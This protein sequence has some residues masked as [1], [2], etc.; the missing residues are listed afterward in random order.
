MKLPEMQ[1]IQLNADGPLAAEMP[2][3]LAAAIR[4]ARDGGVTR[5]LDG[6]IVVSEIGPPSISSVYAD[7]PHTFC[8]IELERSAEAGE[9]PELRTESHTAVLHP[10]FQHQLT[11]LI[12][13]HSLENR[14]NTPDRILAA[15]LVRCLEVFDEATRARDA[16]VSNT[17]RVTEEMVE[18]AVRHELPTALCSVVVLRERMR[19]LLEVA[20]G[21]RE[22]KARWR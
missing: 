13:A 2:H 8:E 22:H 18:R 6:D 12:N 16:S 17:P 7:V 14:S 19:E 21:E 20:V 11:E 4:R 3:H 10:S 5:L 9:P 15:Y 1:T